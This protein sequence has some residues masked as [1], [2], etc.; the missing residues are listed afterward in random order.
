[1]SAMNHE[2]GSVKKK[3]VQCSEARSEVFEEGF[4]LLELLVRRWQRQRLKFRNNRL[5]FRLLLA[6]K[7]VVITLRVMLL[8]GHHTEC[9]DYLSCYSF[10]ITNS[11]NR[12]EAK[13]TMLS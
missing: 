13:L 8:F 4:L 2:E 6:G 1:M 3:S 11:S 10:S 9:D 5:T 12:P 7:S